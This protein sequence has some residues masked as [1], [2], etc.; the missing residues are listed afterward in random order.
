MNKIQVDDTTYSE[1][2]IV[3]GHS[4]IDEDLITKKFSSEFLRTKSIK[5]KKI[6]SEIITIHS[7]NHNFYKSVI[8]GDINTYLESNL[9][10]KTKINDKK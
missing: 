6:V 3:M 5:T 2:M 8:F 10:C 4:N 7:V 9:P 1:L